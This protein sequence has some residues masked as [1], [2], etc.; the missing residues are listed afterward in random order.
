MAAPP[1]L[2]DQASLFEGRDDEV[3]PGDVLVVDLS[4][5]EG[6]LDLLLGLA[7]TRKLD[8][9]AIS[10]SELAAQYLA[11]IDQI[12]GM[13]LEIAADYL[14]MAAWLAFLK[15]KLLL[16]KDEEPSDGPTGDELAAILA[17]RLQRLHAMREAA[18]R[19]MTRSRLGQQVFARGAPEAV[20]TTRDQQYVASL[21]DLLQ[22]Y[23]SQRT[24][25]L[26]AEVKLPERKVWSIREARDRLE[27]LLGRIAVESWSTLDSYLLEVLG[28]APDRRSAVASSFGASLEM[29]REGEIELAQ[30]A[31]FAPIYL[32]RRPGAG[33]ARGGEGEGRDG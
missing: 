13:K 33:D 30:E 28:D 23:A 18:A 20:V 10:M 17:F 2:N 12:E 5:F 15:S 19:L 11:F 8:L 14:V 9:A 25:I 6:P 7:R 32:R 1:E 26:P 4:G 3:D 29:A 16:P 21:T 31:A 24:Q 27:Q 22:A